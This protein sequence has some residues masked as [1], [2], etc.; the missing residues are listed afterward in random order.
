VVSLV[1]QCRGWGGLGR[2]TCNL[3][4]GPL[5][6]S[7]A[8]SDNPHRDGATLGARP[9]TVGLSWPPATRPLA[10]GSLHLIGHA[11]LL[12]ALASIDETACDQIYQS[13]CPR[14][15]SLKILPF[16]EVTRSLHI[17]QQNE[18]LSYHDNRVQI[19]RLRDIFIHYLLLFVPSC[20]GT[21]FRGYA[22]D[23]TLGYL[24]HRDGLAS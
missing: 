16:R 21:L 14:H 19:L 24:L 11:L 13:S 12:S 5:M 7:S 22:F 2:W 20:A 8:S 4:R 9:G 17:L 15:E 3:D 18:T 6:G 1:A 23:D 10:S